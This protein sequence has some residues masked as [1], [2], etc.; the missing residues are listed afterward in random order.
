[1]SLNCE[2]NCK[3]IS[4]WKDCANSIEEFIQKLNDDELIQ[5]YHYF[6]MIK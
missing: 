5:K 6:R 3:D 1:M 2:E 4:K